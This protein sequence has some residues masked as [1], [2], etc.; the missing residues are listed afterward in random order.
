LADALGLD[1]ERAAS[2]VNADRDVVSSQRSRRTAL[3]P[4]AGPMDAGQGLRLAILGPLEAWRD[5]RPLALGPPARRAVLGL[6]AIGPGML[7][8]RDT[9][10]DV[11]WGEEPPRTAMD[12]VQSHISRLRRVLEPPGRS[13]A[14]DGGEVGAGV[15][16]SV[17]GAYRLRV[18]IEQ[19]DLLLFKELAARAAAAQASGD[20]TSACRLYEQAARLWRGDPLADVDLLSGHPGIT[21]LRYQLTSALLRYAELACALGQHRQV[22]PLLQALAASEPLNESV[23]AHLM[24][25]LAGTGQQATAVGVYEDL[26]SRLD[27][28]LGLYPSGELAEAHLRVLRQDIRA[29]SLPPAT[30]LPSVLDP[31]V[32]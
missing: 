20:D 12:L 6:L 27:R 11:L 23:H 7:V 18:S 5:G 15:I 1:P 25:A 26:R 17:R 22:L 13:A 16:S 21:L 2:M 19:V 9:I 14:G 28:E 8:R 29:H 3:A 10:I 4:G 24:I 30:G 32:P 31:P